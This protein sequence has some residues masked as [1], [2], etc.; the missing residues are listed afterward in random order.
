MQS[1][2]RKAILVYEVLCTSRI[3][4][5]RSKTHLKG[6]PV[7]DRS[8]SVTFAVNPVVLKPAAATESAAGFESMGSPESGPQL[9]TPQPEAPLSIET[10]ARVRDLFLRGGLTAEQYE[11]AQADQLGFERIVGRNNQLPVSFLD[12][13]VQ[14]SRATC[15]IEASGVDYTGASGAWVGTG[16]LVSKNL[17][18]TNNHVINSIDVARNATCVFNF[19][20]GADG[21]PATTKRF[22]VRPDRLF[23]TSSAINGLDFTLVWVDGE[24]GNEFGQVRIDRSAFAVGLNEF[25]NVVGH[26]QGRMKEVSLQENNVLWMDEKVVHYSSD[27]EGGSSGSPVSNNSWQVFALHHASKATQVAGQSFLNEGIKFTAIAAHIE[28]LSRGTGAIARQAKEA[29]AIFSAAQNESSGFFGTIGRVGKGEN[30]LES[31]VDSF[32]GTEQDLDVGFWNVEWLTNRWQD[33]LADVAQVIHAMKL[34]VWSLEESSPNAAEALVNELNTNFGLNYAY[35]AAEPDSDDGKQSCTILWNQDTVEVVAETWGEPIE[36][37]IKVKS[38]D[39]DDLGLEA[40]H[41]KVFDRYPRLFH[42]KST[43][44]G[45]IDFYLVAIHLK[46]KDEGS[47]RRQMASKILA[48]AVHKKIEQGADADW[49]IGGDFNA[50]LASQDF[51]ALQQGGL[52]P[53]S[54]GDEGNGEISYVK[55]PFKSM[56]DHIFLSPNL[57]QQY[58]EDSFVV[59]AAERTFPDYIS[60]ISDHRPVLMRMSTGGTDSPLTPEAEPA[61][62]PALDE[63]KALLGMPRPATEESTTEMDSTYPGEEFEKARKRSPARPPRPP[64]SEGSTG[65][66]DPNFLGGGEFAVPVPVLSSAQQSDAVQVNRTGSGMKK[67][68]LDYTHFSVAMNGVRRMPFYAICNIDGKQSKNVARGDDWRFDTRI[69]EEFQCGND[70]YK[71]NDLDKGHMVRRLD[72]VWG[73]TEVATKANSETF[74]YTNAC[75]QHKDLNQKEWL[76]LEDYIL[77]NTNTFDLKVCVFT[78]PVFGNNDRPYR[79]IEIPLEFWKVAVMRNTETGKLS[80]TGYVLTQSDMVSGFEFVFGPFKTYQKS[81]ASIEAMTGLDFGRLKS[82]DPMRSGSGP[83]FESAGTQSVARRIQGRGDIIL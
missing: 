15:K 24:P 8:A 59:V 31:L 63:L 70:I 54:A 39:F 21:K 77:G 78:G 67:F 75:P 71:N 17:L 64:R 28:K 36:T 60:K 74:F 35:L 44:E 2:C 29:L 47:L 3:V 27:T 20:L 61:S 13:G 46:A 65:G 40:V 68:L 34:D 69:G 53:I 56:I 33:K 81:L 1:S 83:G 52:V 43:G 10:R 58:G 49:V 76:E 25:A 66:Y 82:F 26:P 72:P 73:N 51:D 50:E 62:S 80:A 45:T 9:E 55:S 12:I 48:A 42:V 30:D 22:R 11:A 7:A 18:L 14:T 79:G 37:W 5:W 6:P 38:T 16:F 19:Q 32:A 4:R 57:A 23:I 41:G